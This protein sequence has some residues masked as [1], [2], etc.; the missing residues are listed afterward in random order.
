MSKKMVLEFERYGLRQFRILTGVLQILGSLGLVIGFFQPLFT[1]IS[2]LGLAVLMFLGIIT[3]I[4]IRDSLLQT[5]PAFV[6]FSVNL[7]IFILA[8]P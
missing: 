3:R 1:L 2:S 4:R 6:F 8:L 5:A 7:Y